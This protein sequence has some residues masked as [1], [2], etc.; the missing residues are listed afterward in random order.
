MYM[1]FFRP[2]WFIKSL[3]IGDFMNTGKD[4]KKY[5]QFAGLKKAGKIEV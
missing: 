5:R 4:I 1:E 2:K 3:E